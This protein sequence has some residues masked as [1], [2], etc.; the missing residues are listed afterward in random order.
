[1]DEDDRDAAGI[2]GLA[3][4][5]AG[6]LGEAVGQDHLERVEVVEVAHVPVEGVGGGPV[7]GELHA[8]AGERGVVLL[9]RG[10][11]LPGGLRAAVEAQQG[12]DGERLA[13]G[14][15]EGVAAAADGRLG[16][17]ADGGQAEAGGGL[18]RP[19]LAGVHLGG[20]EHR[21]EIGEADVVRA[22]RQDA[23][24]E[25]GGGLVPRFR[26]A[27]QLVE[28]VAD[29]G[30]VAFAGGGPLGAERG[31]FQRLPGPAG[32]VD[33]L[34]AGLARGQGDAL[35]LRRRG[36]AAL[37]ED[38]QGAKRGDQAEPA[39]HARQLE[40]QKARSQP[41]RWNGM[42]ARKACGKRRFFSF[43]TRRP[44]LLLPPADK[45][46]AVVQW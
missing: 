3:E 18:A 17:P 37:G 29:G 16:F 41:R 13:G 1:M 4:V 33:Q 9:E 6:F 14:G 19:E 30:V 22:R 39:E 5:E 28:E 20:G 7:G 10:G 2:V 23:G 25:R 34:R 42:A 38:E 43:Q 46:V 27:A 12:G 45:M 8:A 11:E 44:R 36:R 32:R 31:V 26:A 24:A 35:A 21:V 40:A 15:G